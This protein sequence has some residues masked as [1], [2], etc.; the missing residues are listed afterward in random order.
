MLFNAKLFHMNAVQKTIVSIASVLVRN[1]KHKLGFK[2]QQNNDNVKILLDY[3]I[4]LFSCRKT[5]SGASGLEF[6]V[7]HISSSV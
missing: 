1:V 3:E 4:G 2:M 7:I 6:R 5:T